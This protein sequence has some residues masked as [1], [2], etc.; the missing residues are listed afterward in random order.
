[1]HDPNGDAPLDDTELAELR[2]LVERA[3]LD[4]IEW[5][6]APSGVWNRIAAEVEIDQRS[7][8]STRSDDAAWTASRRRRWWI[9]GAGLT[10]AAAVA[11]AVVVIAD[12]DAPDTQVL[13]SVDLEPLTGSG[14]GSAELV[15]VGEAVQLRLRTSGLASRDDGY[16]EVWLINPSVTE[17]VSLGPLRQDGEYDV[18]AGVDPAA[19]PIVDVS[20]EPVDGDPAHSGE[21]VLRGELPT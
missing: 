13:A 5:E 16:F 15:S 14:S 11:V 20:V 4:D 7:V 21:S 3:A 12:D 1:M 2:S 10:A 19:F 8:R 17:L 18:P 6:P 9:A